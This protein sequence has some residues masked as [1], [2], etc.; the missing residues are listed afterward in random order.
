MQHG[1]LLPTGGIWIPT[2][3][4]SLLC[5]AGGSCMIGGVVGGCVLD[6]LVMACIGLAHKAA[7][8]FPR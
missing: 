4:G 2:H 3:S 5:G 8:R 1:I 6:C 7:C